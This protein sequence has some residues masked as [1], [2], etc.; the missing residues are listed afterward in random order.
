MCCVS[1]NRRSV[2][3]FHFFSLASRILLVV[4]LISFFEEKILGTIDS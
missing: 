2:H 1:F 4:T 3:I